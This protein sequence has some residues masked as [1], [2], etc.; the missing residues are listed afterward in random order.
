MLV[1]DAFDF[2]SEF[3]SPRLVLYPLI[4]LSD[5]S[6]FAYELV[7]L[8]PTSDAGLFLPNKPEKGLKNILLAELPTSLGAGV[9]G[10]VVDLYAGVEFSLRALGGGGGT[11]VS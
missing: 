11:M 7:S 3:L 5:P 1:A 8:L 6:P 2:D 10:A 9:D 4:L